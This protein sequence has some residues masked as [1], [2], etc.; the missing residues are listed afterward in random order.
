MTREEFEL[1][2]RVFL[3]SKR[4]CWWARWIGFFWPAF[5][6]RWWTTVRFPFCRGVIAY[7]IGVAPMGDAWRHVRQHELAHVRQQRG[8]RL[9]WTALLY[10]VLPLPILF[11]GRWFVEREP[12]LREIVIGRRTVDQVV[13]ILWKS[14]VYPWPRFLM[15]KWLQKKSFEDVLSPK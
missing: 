6:Y 10:F 1:Q 13:D 5:Q 12:Y 3:R 14:Y 2:H 9:Y 8:L 7:P 11:S 4:H 15:R